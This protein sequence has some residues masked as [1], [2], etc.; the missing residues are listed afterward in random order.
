VALLTAFVAVERGAAHPL[1]ALKP[2][3]DPGRDRLAVRAVRNPV[4]DP[5]AHRLPDALSP[6]RVGLQPRSCGR[7][8]LAKR[9]GS[10]TAHW[11]KTK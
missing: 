3:A 4:R 9:D 10:L 11:N 8:R 7:T 1:I 6:A 5:R 2:G